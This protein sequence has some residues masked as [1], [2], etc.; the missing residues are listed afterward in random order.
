MSG[1]SLVLPALKQ[2]PG[3]AVEIDSNGAII[4]TLQSPD[5]R[6]SGISE[7]REVSH[8]NNQRLLYVGS[9]MNSYLG[10]LILKT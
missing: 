1:L 5:N 6:F 7:V 3:M 2:L 8:E 9:P 10:K 4:T